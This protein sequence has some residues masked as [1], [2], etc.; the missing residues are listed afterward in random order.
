MSPID[1]RTLITDSL[2]IGVILFI[3][4]T[5]GAVV[6]AISEVPFLVYTGDFVREG[7]FSL[8]QRSPSCTSY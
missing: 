5:I 4:Y 2:K 7:L 1:V 6:N 3:S 8:G